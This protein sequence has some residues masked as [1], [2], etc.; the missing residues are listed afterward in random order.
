MASQS[1]QLYSPDGH[2]SSVNVGP[3][4]QSITFRSVKAAWC[5][6]ATAVMSGIPDDGLL[7]I[8]DLIVDATIGQIPGYP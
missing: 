7:E 8:A 6:L 4:C 2:V 3:T 5:E 1:I